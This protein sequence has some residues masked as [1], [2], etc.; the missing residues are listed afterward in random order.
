[1]GEED[2]VRIISFHL[3]RAKRAYQIY[4][5]NEKQFLYARLIK[6]ANDKIVEV[7]IENITQIPVE[8]EEDAIALLEHLEIWKEH[9]ED[10]ERR[11]DPKLTDEFV[12]ENKHNF[13]V[14]SVQRI[15]HFY[16]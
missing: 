9:W 5:G 16:K 6:K 15:E 4:L 3:K 10:L 8:I 14:E 13:P 2:F 1:M 7:I 11:M 12:F